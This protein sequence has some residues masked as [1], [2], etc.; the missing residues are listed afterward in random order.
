M[1][2]LPSVPAE[3]S[4]G[5]S[6]VIIISKGHQGSRDQKALATPDYKYTKINS[7]R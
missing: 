7:R 2:K 6:N 5:V 1:E 3:G 4:Q